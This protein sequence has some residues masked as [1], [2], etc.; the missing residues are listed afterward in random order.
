MRI[1]TWNCNG[2]LRR[3]FHKIEQFKADIVIIQECENPE[4]TADKIYKKW[5]SNFLWIGENKNKGLGIF[6]KDPLK[7]THNKWETNGT[8]YFI[9]ANINK[10]FNIVAAWNH[11][12]N[13]PNFGYIGQFWKYLQANKH[14]MTSSII[15]AGDFNSNKIWDEWDRWWNHSDVVREL[16]DINI[17][18]LYHE[19]FKEL[20]GKEKTPTLYLQRN[21]KKPY[22]VDYVFADRKTFGKIKNIEIGK[23]SEWLKCSDHMPIIFK[24]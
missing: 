16:E 6:C 13:S 7:L 14:L 3:K 21:V 2:A 19:H 8:K 15:I 12:A 18:S 4:Q 24:V 9:S 1:I 17:R 10:R 22:H 20:Q 11:H 5:A 23:R